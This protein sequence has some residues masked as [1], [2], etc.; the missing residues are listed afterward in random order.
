MPTGLFGNQEVDNLADLESATERWRAGGPGTPVFAPAA[1]GGAYM[2]RDLQQAG[3]NPTLPSSAAWQQA[4]RT[5]ANAP[6][7]AN[8]F[9]GAIANQSRNQQLALIEQLRQQMMGPS[10]AAMQG[11]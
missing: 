1:S 3:F 4:A 8:P 5:G 9:S 2:R 10:L 7:R 6:M 11:Q